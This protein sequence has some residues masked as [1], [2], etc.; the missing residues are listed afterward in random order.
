M[1][2]TES[3]DIDEK[4][5]WWPHPY[6][7]SPQD[8]RRR[9]STAVGAAPTRKMSSRTCGIFVDEHGKMADVPLDLPHRLREQLALTP[10]LIVL[11]HLGF[12]GIIQ[13]ISTL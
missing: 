8:K 6:S 12:G 10:F 2:D 3:R 1:P 11:V 13:F 5:R 9:Q 7:P 4:N